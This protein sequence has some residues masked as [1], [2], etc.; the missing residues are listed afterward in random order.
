ML[1]RT[2]LVK[3]EDYDASEHNYPSDLVAPAMCPVRNCIRLGK[4]IQTGI[5]VK[6]TWDRQAHP[7]IFT[8][9]MVPVERIDLVRAQD[10]NLL[11][12]RATSHGCYVP[13][14]YFIQDISEHDRACSK[15]T[16]VEL[17]MN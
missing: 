13:W 1:H 17:A 8:A 2:T 3:D 5:S 9:P 4:Q 10:V 11:R 7:F 15:T 12:A 6:Y 14:V 16:Q